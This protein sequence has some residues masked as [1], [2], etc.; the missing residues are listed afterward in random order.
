ME[1]L[2]RRT[3]E[4]AKH[5]AL[6]V[7]NNLVTFELAQKYFAI[8]NT[9]WMVTQQNGVCSEEDFPDQGRRETSREA[10]ELRTGTTERRNC[11]VQHRPR[12]F[13][14]SSE[15]QTDFTQ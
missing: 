12:E 3:A 8:K 13:D 11:C 5:C 10:F 15:L 9:V 7:G 4:F 6:T 2:G 14:L 1:R